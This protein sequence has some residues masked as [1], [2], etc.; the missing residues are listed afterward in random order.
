MKKALLYLFV[1][2]LSFLFTQI[3][4][5]Q[6]TPRINNFTLDAIPSGNST[7]DNLVANYSTGSGVVE[8]TSAWYRD[9][10]PVAILY[11]PFEGG[12]SN[13]LRDFSGNSNHVTTTGSPSSTPIWDASAGRNGTG[14]F[15]FDG[16]D[17]FLAGDIL[18]LNSSYTKTAWVYDTGS[19]YRNIISSELQIDNNH[20]FNIHPD[21]TL[22]AGHSFGNAIVSDRNP[23]RQDR[24]YSVAVTFDYETG[25][26]VLYKNGREVDAAIVPVSL[27]SVVDPAVLIGAKDYLYGWQGTIDEPCIYDRA[28][29]AE[30]IYSLHTSGEDVFVPAETHGGEQWQVRVTPF[31]ISEVGETYLSNTISLQRANI[32]SLT[33]TASSVDNLTVDSYLYQQFISG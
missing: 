31:S 12:P 17:Y 30:Q 29:T 7:N 3:T 15:N 22:N 26:M 18:P 8:T 5:A 4:T 16:S 19:G 20:S 11:L 2:C 10:S 24:W 32:S 1:V 33:L 14:A 27:R 21:G 25:K 9:G 28:L 23:L 13:A 6:P